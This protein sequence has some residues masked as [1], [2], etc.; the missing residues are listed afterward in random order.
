MFVVRACVFVLF[1]VAFIVLC[2]LFVVCCCVLCAFVVVCVFVVLCGVVMF[3]RCCFCLCLCVRVCCLV[4]CFCSS[5]FP[6]QS[7]AVGVL[8]V[9]VKGPS[10]VRRHVDAAPKHFSL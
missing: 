3:F 4:L 9:L 5:L 10:T 2:C 8:T 6:K 1:V 7:L